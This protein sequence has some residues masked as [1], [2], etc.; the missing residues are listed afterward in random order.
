MMLLI[1]DARMLS[2]ATSALEETTTSALTGRSALLATCASTRAL[3][4]RMPRTARETMLATDGLL[5]VKL[6]RELTSS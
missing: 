4:A 6:I 5:E 2:T 1:T 3:P